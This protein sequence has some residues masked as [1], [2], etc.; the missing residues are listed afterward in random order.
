[1][2]QPMSALPSRSLSG[3]SRL[4]VRL[5]GACASITSRIAL[6][7]IAIGAMM[8]DIRDTGLSGG[9]SASAGRLPG[10]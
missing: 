4:P 7:A 2:F 9:G 6:L 8:V 10:G 1:M 3:L 5:R